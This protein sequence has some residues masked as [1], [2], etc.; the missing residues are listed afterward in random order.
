M[1]MDVI[2]MHSFKFIYVLILL[3]VPW[4]TAGKNS[5]KY[6]KYGYLNFN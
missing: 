3:V 6:L 4:E 5:V 2:K 1:V